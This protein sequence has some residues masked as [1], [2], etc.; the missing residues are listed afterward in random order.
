MS[1]IEEV[2]PLHQ[3]ASA[4]KIAV[5]QDLLAKGADKNERNNN[6]Q[7]PLIEAVKGNHIELLQYL[8][9]QGADKEKADSD[10]YTALMHA[11]DKGELRVVR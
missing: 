7:T 1:N 10:S 8:V 2:F 9:E 3:A 11:A 4:G 5:V 6:G